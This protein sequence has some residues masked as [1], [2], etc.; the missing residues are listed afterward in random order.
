MS[1]IRHQT[2]GNNS[3]HHQRLSSPLSLDQSSI[4]LSREREWRMTLSL[5]GDFLLALQHTAHL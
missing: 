5:G 3:H 4:Q 1:S 2:K